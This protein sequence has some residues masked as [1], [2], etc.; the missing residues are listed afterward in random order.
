[1]W[2]FTKKGKKK[3]AKR[4]WLGCCKGEKL[5]RHVLSESVWKKEWAHLLT[6]ALV[7]T[8]RVS[9]WELH[10]VSEGLCFSVPFKSIHTCDQTFL[11]WNVAPC[12]I[13][14]LNWK[15]GN[16]PEASGLW[17]RPRQRGGDG[18]LLK[19]TALERGQKW[20]WVMKST[21]RGYLT[22]MAG[23]EVGYHG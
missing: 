1:M 20:P 18:C 12:S 9:M 19:F 15:Y 10:P 22:W 5:S 3:A 7:F 21:R 16:G 11:C 17:V 8:A 4:S 23:L 2:L 13:T 14:L 6:P